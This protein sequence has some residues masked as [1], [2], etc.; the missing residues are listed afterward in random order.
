MSNRTR[1]MA[2]IAVALLTV[3]GACGDDDD[4]TGSS[5]GSSPST[6][7][8]DG[9]TLSL[10]VDE[11]RAVATVTADET[12]TVADPV[13]S[14]TIDDTDDGVIAYGRLPRG[15]EDSGAAAPHGVMRLVLAG[16]SFELPS[17]VA[18]A[19]DTT[20]VCLEVA[21]ASADGDQ[22]GDEVIVDEEI[23]TR[24]VCADVG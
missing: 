23:G 15:G 1:L 5:S 7:P 3:V 18:I 12:I 22:T 21:P 8:A 9:V 14:A 17:P 2:A 16:D 20:R 11:D 10:A 13:V 19:D 24:F 6:V 4:P